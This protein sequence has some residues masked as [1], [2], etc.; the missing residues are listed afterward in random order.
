MAAA[1]LQDVDLAGNPVR[2]QFLQ[3]HHHRRARGVEHVQIE[4]EPRFEV[5]E[6][7]EAFLQQLGIDIAA[8]GDEHDADVLVALVAHIFQDRQLAIGDGRGDLFDQL[9][10][11][12]L[13]RNLIDHELPLAAAQ[14]LDPRLAILVRARLRRMETRAQAETAAPGLISGSDRFRA[15]HHK[16]TGREIGSVE[17]LH[18]PGMFDLRIVDQF[19]RRIDHLGDIVARDIGRHAHRDPARSVGEQIGE[20][21]GKD[22]RLALFAVVGRDEIDRALVQPLHQ[23][24]RGFGQARFGVAIGGCV[25]AVDIAEIPLPLDQRIPQREILREADHRIVDARIAMRVILADH[26]ADDAGG[27]LERVGRVQLQLAHRP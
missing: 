11:L 6:L 3:P 24:Q 8:A 9:A 12:H 15:V 20:Q 2:Q 23:A 17:Q 16:R 4:A 10:L 1:T 27:F 22:L 25:I 7:V 26:V 18:Q 5:S 14:P 19:Q 13:I 21:A